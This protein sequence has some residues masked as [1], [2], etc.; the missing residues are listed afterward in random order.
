MPSAKSCTLKLWDKINS[1]AREHG[2]FR[3]KDAIVLAVSGGPDSVTMLDFFAK[4][5]RRRR[6]VLLIAHL[7][8]KLRGKDSDKDEAFVKELGRAYG[9]ETVTGRADIPALAKRRKTGL[10]HAARLARYDFLT[11]LALKRKFRLIATAHHA[12]D[13]AETFLLNLLRGTEPKGL[14]GIPVKRT[15][16]G[17][18]GARVIRP[19]LRV[20]RAEIMEYVKANRLSHRKDKS[21]EDEKFLRNWVR[22]TL[23]PLIERKQP[24]FKAHLAE[25]SAKLAPL[26]G[27]ALP[28]KSAGL[29]KHLLKS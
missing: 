11:K 21:N 19:L 1:G 17:K 16:A 26:F 12:D 13:H 3:D 28:G 25:L 7:N 27:R 4:L 2:L 9:I 22:K 15:L 8:H 6:L 24:R 10:E 5:A 29:A 20:T 18:G 23:I 14:L